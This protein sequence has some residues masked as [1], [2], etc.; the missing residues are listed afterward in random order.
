[1]IFSN[2][3]PKVKKFGTSKR[4]SY[5]TKC[6]NHEFSIMN[7]EEPIMYGAEKYSH[8]KLREMQRYGT[9]SIN[10]G[11]VLN[12]IF[13]DKAIVIEQNDNIIKALVRHSSRYYVAVV[14]TEIMKIKTFLPD[15]IPNL[16]GYVQQLMDK[17]NSTPWAFVA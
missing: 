15:N 12:D 8:P 16:L 3:L 13:N 11:K 7:N 17:E 4:N 1:M 9:R 14:D 2:R 10:N 5:K 6:K